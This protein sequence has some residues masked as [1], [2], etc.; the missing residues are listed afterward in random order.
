MPAE[1]LYGIHAVLEA[2]QSEQRG[3]EK[4]L[5]DE[6]R[7]GQRV[8]DLVAL[9]QRRSV[10]VALVKAS[11][12]QQWLGHDRHQGVAALVYALAYHTLESVCTSLARTT[13]AQTLLVLDGVT[14]VG[15]F[16]TLVRSAVAFGVEAII[17]PRH[18]S[19][20][21]SPMVAK[22]SAGALEHIAVV[23]VGNIVRALMLL[24][25][26]G[27][28]VYGADARAGTEVLR[29]AWPQRSVVVL[30]SEGRG[31]RRLVREQCDEI[32]SIPMRPGVD[33]VN[34]AVAGSIIVASIWA[35][36]VRCT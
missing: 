33:S 9:A 34:V 35:Q 5:I 32:V 30:G 2:L 4:V 15:N 29:V 18:R 23:Q 16:A 3:V 27:C 6:R 8:Q 10:P 11:D 13:E 14:D 7:R 25:Q 36:R 21:L 28:W 19:V 22:R 20:G 31:L 1:K 17:V 12:L 26:A 24:K